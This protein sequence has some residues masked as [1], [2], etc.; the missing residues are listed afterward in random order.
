MNVLDKWERDLKK[1]RHLETSRN[2]KRNNPA[3]MRAYVNKRRA[4]KDQATPA[5]FDKEEV[6]Y[7]YSLASE[8]GLQ[9][10]HIVPLKSKYV[11]GLHVQDNMRCIPASLNRK[12][13]N[14]Y[15]NDMWS[16]V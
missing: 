9:V 10:D 6:D 7:I 14:I 1:E 3:K 11:C 13:S 16:K 5:W 12:K 4:D 8:R 15:W 2:W